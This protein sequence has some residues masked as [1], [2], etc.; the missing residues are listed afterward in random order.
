MDKREII[1]RIVDSSTGEIF[2]ETRHKLVCNFW[3]KKDRNDLHGFLDIFIEKVR[4]SPAE[5][6][7]CID[8]ICDVPYSQLKLPF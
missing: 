2:N 7:L 3:H 5:S 4:N 1:I 6:S 8:F